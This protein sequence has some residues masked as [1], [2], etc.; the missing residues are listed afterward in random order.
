VKKTT[1][2]STGTE[3]KWKRPSIEVKMESSSEHTDDR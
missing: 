3:N 2:S 1:E